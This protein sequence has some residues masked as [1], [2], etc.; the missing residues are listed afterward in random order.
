MDMYALK[1]EL[2]IIQ[3]MI[4]DAIA[5]LYKVQIRA[6]ESNSLISQTEQQRG[7][8]WR[9]GGMKSHHLEEMTKLA[10]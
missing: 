7:K 1:E 10:R 3:S 5:S 6:S 4:S 8:K 2:G 9:N